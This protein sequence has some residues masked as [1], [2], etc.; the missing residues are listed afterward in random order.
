MWD[1]L[2]RTLQDILLPI[3]IFVV[4]G[5][6][7]WRGIKGRFMDMIILIVITIVGL[8]FFLNPGII[9]SLAT[10]AGNQINGS[11]GGTTP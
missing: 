8:I 6:A 4:G 5:L 7:V 2:I 11:V 9:E 1:G 10:S 3:I